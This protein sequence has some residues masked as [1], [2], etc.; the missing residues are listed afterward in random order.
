MS[1][2][3]HIISCVH[4][5]N[6]KEHDRFAMQYF[7]L[8]EITW[9]EEFMKEEHQRDLPGGKVTHA[10]LHSDNI[11]SHFKSTRAIKVFTSRIMDQEGATT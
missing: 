5:L 8:E 11:G 3:R 4:V 2:K 7:L 1:S 9:L 10:Y 6:D